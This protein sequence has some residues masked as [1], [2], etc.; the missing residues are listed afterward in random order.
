MAACAMDLRSTRNL[1]IYDGGREDHV[2][3]PKA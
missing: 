2:A 1:N 3:E